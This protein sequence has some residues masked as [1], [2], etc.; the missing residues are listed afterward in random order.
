MSVTREG[1]GDEGFFGGKE[2]EQKKTKKEKEEATEKVKREKEEEK[3][4]NRIK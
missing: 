3:K 4:M 2:M 1:R